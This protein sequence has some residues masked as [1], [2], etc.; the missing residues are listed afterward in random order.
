MLDVSIKM[1][2]LLQLM[3]EEDYN[4]EA[5]IDWKCHAHLP[6]AIIVQ[7]DMIPQLPS[8]LK[9]RMYQKLQNKFHPWLCLQKLD[10]C[11]TVSSRAFDKVQGMEFCE[12][13]RS[14]Y[15]RGLLCCRGTL[16][17]LYKKL[18]QYGERLLPYESTPNSVKFDVS[19]VMEY[20]MEWHGVWELVIC[21]QIALL[22]ATVD[23][24]VP[25]LETDS[26]IFWGEIG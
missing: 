22:Y 19:Q 21:D 5:M 14:K 4:E 7:E 24:R 17:W 16:I 15:Q 1:K 25:C 11:T 2:L 9:T 26:S 20:L 6:K 13:Q 8:H 23:R 18:E 10:L 12:E 3:S